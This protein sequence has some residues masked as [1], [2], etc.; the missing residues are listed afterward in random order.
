[1]GRVIFENGFLLLKKDTGRDTSSSARAVTSEHDVWN[2]N[3][4]IVAVRRVGL[5]P[6]PS[7]HHAEDDRA[8]SW[9]NLGI[10]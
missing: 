8:E 6:N 3:S 7:C 5:R 4:H 10:G 2:L 1:M 9:K